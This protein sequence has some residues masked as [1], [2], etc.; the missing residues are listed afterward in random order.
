LM[1]LDGEQ[2]KVGW[3]CWVAVGKFMVGL[4]RTATIMRCG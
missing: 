3:M 1:V 2:L 4:A